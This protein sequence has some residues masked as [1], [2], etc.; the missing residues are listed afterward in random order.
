MDVVWIEELSAEERDGLMEEVM[1]G[2]LKEVLEGTLEE[3]LGARKLGPFGRRPPE[4]LDMV[5]GRDNRVG[6]AAE[7]MGAVLG[8]NVLGP[9]GLRPPEG[10]D[11]TGREEGRLGI[12]E[13]GRCACA[14][15]GLE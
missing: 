5:L 8:D 12:I 11:R 13:C 10:R 3:V 1:E 4:G 9:I 15:S 2:A 14:C 6:L 7:V